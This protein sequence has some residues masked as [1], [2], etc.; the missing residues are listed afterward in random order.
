MSATCPLL[1][2]SDVSAVNAWWDLGYSDVSRHVSDTL[3]SGQEF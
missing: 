1:G 2:K 3:E